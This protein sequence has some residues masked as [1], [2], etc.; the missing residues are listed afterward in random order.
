MVQKSSKLKIVVKMASQIRVD[1]DGSVPELAEY[2]VASLDTSYLQIK[3]DLFVSTVF[4]LFIALG[5]VS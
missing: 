5:A 2:A 3:T 1:V 4:T